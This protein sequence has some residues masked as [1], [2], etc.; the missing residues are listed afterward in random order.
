MR[1]PARGRFHGRVSTSVTPNRS[2]RRVA[3][4]F[5][6]ALA[7]VLVIGGLAV[8]GALIVFIVAM[9]NYGSNK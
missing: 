7:V 9:N 3:L 2:W 8:V 6:I 4:A 1:R 5:G